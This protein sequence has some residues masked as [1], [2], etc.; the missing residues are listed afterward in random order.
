MLFIN[1]FPANLKL[2]GKQRK[3]YARLTTN[4]WCMWHIIHTFIILYVED[5]VP[6]M[7]F[8]SLK[9]AAE[10]S[11]MNHFQFRKIW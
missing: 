2:F 10:I 4:A 6:I 9:V 8:F 3:H 1:S 5:E 11:E 7:S